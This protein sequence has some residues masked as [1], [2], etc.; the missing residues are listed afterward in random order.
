MD[1]NIGTWK[2]SERGAVAR[3]EAL[4]GKAGANLYNSPLSGLKVQP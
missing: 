3:G 4:A 1:R 2:G